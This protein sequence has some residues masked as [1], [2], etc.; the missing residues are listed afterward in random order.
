MLVINNLFFIIKKAK[1]IINYYVL[2]KEEFYKVYKSD[3]CYYI[4]IC[5]DLIYK[6]RIRVFLLK[7]KGIIIIIFI[8]YSYSPVIY[9]KNKQ[10][11]V[12]WY[13]KD[14]YK[15]FFINNK[16]LTLI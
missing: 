12:L 3:C 11:L 8:I 13:L 1:N 9:Y 16:T 5:K 10:F 4:I 7:K 6:F 2:D 14:Y 15:A